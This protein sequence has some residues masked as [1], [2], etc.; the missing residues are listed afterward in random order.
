MALDRLLARERE[1]TAA[2]RIREPE[3]E[4]VTLALHLDPT[5]R[6][7]H[8]V[9]QDLVVRTEQLCD[10]TSPRRSFIVV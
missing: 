3:H 7:G 4:P 8:G 6:L 9:A 5:V 1:R 2:R 10:R